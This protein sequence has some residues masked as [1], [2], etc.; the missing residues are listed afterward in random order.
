M[1]AAD[2]SFDTRVEQPLELTPE[3]LLANDIGEG[4]EIVAVGAAANG[5]VSFEDGVIEYLADFDHEGLD[6]FTYTV[7]DG[8]AQAQATVS[9]TVINDFDTVEEGGGGSDI[10]SGTRGNDLV[11]GGAGNDVLSGRAGDD[12]LFGGEGA[13][14]VFGGSGS[15]LISGDEGNDLLIGGAGSDTVRGGTGS[16]FISGGR[17]NDDL[18]GGAGR[19][20]LTGG[21][22]SDTFRFSDGDGSD[23]VLGFEATRARR[24]GTIPGDTLAIDV[25]GIDD[26]AALMATAQQTWAG[27]LF[28][29][30]AGDQVFLA[31]TRLAALDEDQFTFY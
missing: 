12:A 6:Q 28:D 15:D 17:G 5:A 4:L 27:V 30:G 24:S 13:D 3:M 22:G 19:D 31:G 23:L 29:F 9:V 10:Q 11:S 7:S 21:G 14:I 16:D 26:Y 8:E 2:D 18:S 25:D 1:N 20:I